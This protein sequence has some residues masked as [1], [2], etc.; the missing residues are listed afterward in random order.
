MTIQI[1]NQNN[2]PEWAVI[3]YNQYL[4]LVEKAELFQDIQDFDKAKA[5][6]ARG[7]EKL[8]PAEVV[9]AILDGVDAIKVWRKFRGLTQADLAQKIDISVPYL[10][11]LESGKRKGSV[12]VL[13]AIAKALKVSLEELLPAES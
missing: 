13:A 12:D 3:P 4:K 8:I 11:Q 9:N 1:I 10:S 7:E 5:A 6:I 2:K